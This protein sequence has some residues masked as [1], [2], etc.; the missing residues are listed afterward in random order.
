VW[1]CLKLEPIIL[2]DAV[3]KQVDEQNDPTL[4]DLVKEVL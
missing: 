4:I 1:Y 2:K 3:P